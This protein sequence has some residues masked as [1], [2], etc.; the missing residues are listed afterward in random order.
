M[1]SKTATAMRTPLREIRNQAEP[2]CPEDS[3]KQSSA[4]PIR[5]IIL[6]MFLGFS[7]VSDIFNVLLL[8]ELPIVQSL[9]SP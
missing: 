7:I 3:R 8:N 1:L 5:I 9:Y 6:L 4:I 2:A